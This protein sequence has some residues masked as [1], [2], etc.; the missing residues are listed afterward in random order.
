MVRDKLTPRY[1]VG[2]KR[3]GFHNDYL[4]TFNRDNVH[5]ETD[6]ISEITRSAIQTTDGGEHE[7]D[8][9][10]CAT[11]FKVFEVGNIPPFPVSG[12]GGTELGEWWDQNR[13]QAY[14]GVSV[15]GFPN[16]F[17]I[18]GPYGYNGSSYFNLIENQSRH[19]MR[20]IGRA[21]SER[22]T[23]VEVRPEANDRYFKKMLSRRSWQILEQ[24]A[25]A[26]ANSYYFD[27]HGDRPFRI[28]PTLE[29]NWQSGHFDLDDYSF[30]RLEP[31]GS[32]SPSAPAASLL[33]A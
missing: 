23:K 1:P 28:S 19:I 3:P 9:L 29:V 8:V 31:G 5:L 11:G 2:C 4:A 12:V 17:S 33:S 26:L 25:C 30:A 20:C 10:I 22:A 18:L 15:P 27:K 32:A 16:F 13:F 7:I 14:Q 6:P 24:P 21:R